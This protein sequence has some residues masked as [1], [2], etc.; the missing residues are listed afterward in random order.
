[1]SSQKVEVIKR[2]DADGSQSIT[3]RYEGKEVGTWV[4]LLRAMQSD[5]EFDLVISPPDGA[6]WI[7]VESTNLA[8]V[9]YDKD[10]AHLLIQFLNGA[11]YKYEGVSLMTYHE[12]LTADSKGRYFAAHIKDKYPC[13]RV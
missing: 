8:R 3:L 4:D 7:D 13:E 5:Y 10:S 2:E 1:V 11:T 6:A 9:R 12:L